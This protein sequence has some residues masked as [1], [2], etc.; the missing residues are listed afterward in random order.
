MEHKYII[1]LFYIILIGFSIYYE[2]FYKNIVKEKFEIEL[3]KWD[4]VIGLQ[5]LRDMLGIFFDGPKR[6][7]NIPG[8]ISVRE[9]VPS[10]AKLNYKPSYDTAFIGKFKGGNDNLIFELWRLGFHYCK[11]SSTECD[12]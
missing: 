4:N 1:F 5:V 2:Y 10:V 9:L 8:G 3:G 11:R 6:T 12:R 7:F